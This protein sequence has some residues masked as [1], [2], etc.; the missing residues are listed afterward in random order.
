MMIRSIFLLFSIL[1]STLLTAEYLG[2]YIARLSQND[3]Y[4][5]RGYPLRHASDILQQDRANYHRFGLRDPEDTADSYFSSRSHRARLRRMLRRGWIEPGLA[6]EIIDGTPLVKVDIYS[7]RIEVRGAGQ[8]ENGANADSMPTTGETTLQDVE[9]VKED[10]LRKLR[11][12][13]PDLVRIL[14]R[15]GRLHH[16]ILASLF[17]KKADEDRLWVVTASRP[18]RNYDCHA[19]GPALSVFEYQWHEKGWSPSRST[20]GLTQFGAWGRGPE[21][22]DM[23]IVKIAPD[24]CALAIRSFYATQGWSFD[25]YTL[26]GNTGQSFKEIFDTTLSADNSATGMPPRTNWK[27]RLRF[28]PGSG[29]YYDI[30][31]HRIGMKD[32]K[33][34]DFT[35]T[36]SFDGTKYRSNRPDPLA[37]E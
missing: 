8:S 36:Y 19:C 2:S 21:E 13:N 35:V 32:G 5:S 31:L 26:I 25:H 15:R 16:E 17:C 37:K 14:Q 11:H 7:R 20:Y 9:A 28:H 23:A 22:K 3:H 6:E 29:S 10:V 18:I 30:R 34:I 1:S 4:S 27:T 12:H 24:R 33:R